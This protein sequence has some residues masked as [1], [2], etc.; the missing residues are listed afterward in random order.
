M[1]KNTDT[2]CVE[3]SIW[4]PVPVDPPTTLSDFTLH[5]SDVDPS[6]NDR[7]KESGVMSFH[8]AGCAGDFLHHNYQ[9]AV[10]NAMAAQVYSPGFP[11]VSNGPATNAS[12]FFH[13]GDVVYKP[14]EVDKKISG[15]ESVDQQQ[16]YNDQFYMPYKDYNRS[17]FAIAGNHDGKNSPSNDSSAI[18]HF[19]LN[20]CSPQRTLSPDNQTDGR[21]AMNQPYVYWR[22]DTPLAYIIGLYSNIANGG[23]LD[24]PTRHPKGPQYQWLVEQLKAVKTQNASNAQR[25]AVLLAVHYPPY[26]GA[27]N[28]KKRGDPTLGPS[29]GDATARPFG[30]LLEQA[31]KESGQRPDVVFSAHAH[32]YQRLTYCYHDRWEVPYIIAGCGGHAPIENMWDHCN[33]A[34]PPAMPKILPFDVVLPAGLKLPA[35]SRVQVHACNDQ[36]F[37]FL[38]VTIT[39]GQLT[40]EFFAVTQDSLTLADAFVLDMQAHQV[41]NLFPTT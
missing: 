7:I 12:F 14:D 17:I 5:L 21:L 2:T 33:P 22:L 34:K 20:F 3:K 4:T 36:S 41:R 10:A 28:F 30:H 40:G 29:P 23:I 27:T 31:F 24:D 37:G 39:E 1:D 11:G 8:M 18:H 19:L 25:K 9:Q 26:S 13:L 16:M 6:E 35:G 15:N 38:R 32:L